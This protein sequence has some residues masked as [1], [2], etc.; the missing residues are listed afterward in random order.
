MR[1]GG[2]ILPSFYEKRAVVF[3]DP[4]S[5][6]PVVFSL[7]LYNSECYF[8]LYLVPF[9]A[10]RK[11]D[12][13][14]RANLFNRMVR[15]RRPRGH[16]TRKYYFGCISGVMYPYVYHP[17]IQRSVQ[18]CRPSTKPTYPLPPPPHSLPVLVPPNA[19]NTAPQAHVQ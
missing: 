19:P 16:A 12:I 15:A 3:G 17:G 2:H 9:C 4:I 18:P 6:V 14:T 13:N 10:R 7:K 5:T 8:W 11:C 1:F